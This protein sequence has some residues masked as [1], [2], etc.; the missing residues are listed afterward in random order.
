[1][2]SPARNGSLLENEYSGRAIAALGSAGVVIRGRSMWR[3]MWKGYGSSPEVVDDA[4]LDW[5]CEGFSSGVVTSWRRFSKAW[6]ALFRSSLSDVDPALGAD[7]LE[8]RP[9]RAAF[10]PMGGPQDH[11][12]L[13]LG[14]SLNQRRIPRK[15]PPNVQGY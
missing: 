9:F 8:D 13:F 11:F 6:T 10:P 3:S 1:M 2:F 12:E 5:K 15:I 4:G 7:S 14:F